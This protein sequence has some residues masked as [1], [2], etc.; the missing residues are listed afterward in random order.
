MYIEYQKNM[1]GTGFALLVF[2]ASNG[3]KDSLSALRVSNSMV[4]KV[5]IFGNVMI[6]M[7]QL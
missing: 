4:F 6:D 7:Y 1:F 2:K 3:L 5:S